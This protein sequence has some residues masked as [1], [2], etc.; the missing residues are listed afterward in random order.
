MDLKR[1]QTHSWPQSKRVTY[2]ADEDVR[3]LRTLAYGY[4]SRNGVSPRELVSSSISNCLL[5]RNT[6]GVRSKQRENLLSDLALAAPHLGSLGRCFIVVLSPSFSYLVIL[7]VLDTG[8][9]PPAMNP[10]VK[11]HCQTYSP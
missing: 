7:R 10:N 1:S 6:R 9:I 11:L 3:K 4:Y 2:T 8:N 5:P